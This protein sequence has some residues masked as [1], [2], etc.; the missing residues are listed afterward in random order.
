[1]AYIIADM[2]THTSCSDGALQPGQ[3]VQKASE[4]G[5]QALA[6]TDHDTIDGIHAA[7]T[8][9]ISADLDIIP[10]VELSIQFLG[11]ELHLLGYYFDSE[12]AALNSFLARYQLL[13]TERA[14]AIVDRLNK[15]GVA[16]EMSEVLAISE[17]PA[18]GRP[19]IAQALVSKGYVDTF[20]QAFLRYLRNGGPADVAKQLPKAEEAIATLHQAGGIAVLAHPGNWVSDRDLSRLKAIGLDGVEIIHPSHDETLTIF[21]T[22]VA[23]RLNL[24]TTG[25]SDFHGLKSNDEKNFGEIG[26]T[27]PQFDAFQLMHDAKKAA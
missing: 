15:L 17:G 2:H 1:M 12:H 27:R 3:L 19:H 21:Y 11:R 18:V 25:G 20:G 22:D 5:I 26:L 6:I 16:L 13:R 4:R 10:G 7:R 23:H 9:A 24:L 8:A 14:Q